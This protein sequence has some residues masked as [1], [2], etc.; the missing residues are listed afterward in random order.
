MIVL[1]PARLDVEKQELSIGVRT[2]VLQRKPY[3]VFLYLIENRHRMVGR[4]ELL[5]RFWDGQ[6][7]YDQSLSK[8]VG[9]IRKALGDSGP[10]LIETRWGL[11]Y[12]YI[13]PFSESPATVHASIPVIE[14]P[15]PSKEDA[16]DSALPAPP[17]EAQAANPTIELGAANPIAAAAT[18]PISWPAT[19]RRAPRSF[20]SWLLPS[21]LVVS[22]LAILALA[23][24][25]F[26]RHEATPAPPA[27]VVPLQ[28]RSIAVLPFTGG[29]K[30]SDDQYMGLELADAV[31]VR[32]MTVSQLDVRSSTTVR[33]VLGLHG[34][35]SLAGA[36]LAVQDVVVGEM[37]RAKDTV[38]LNV[39]LLDSATGTILWSGT[40]NADNTNIFT[41]E[42][43]IARQVA[44]AL[45]PQLGTNA[46][47]RSPAQ[48][49]SRPEAYS[50][51]MKAKFFATT[52]TRDSLAKAIALL[53]EAIRIDPNY[54][55]A[56]ATLADC[57]QL[58][59]FYGFAPPSDAYPRAE[60]AA[61]KALSLDNSIGEAHVAWMSALAD[62]DWD[63]RGAEREFKAT[64]AIDPNYAVAYQ[65]YGYAL[66]AMN[67]GDE[68][69][70]AM[71]QAALLDPV[72][73]SIQTT[74]AWGYYL[75]REYSQAVD[76]C[77]RVLELYPEFVPAHQLLGIVYSQMGLNQ[78]SMTELT[79]A[80][81]LER[82]D[83]I[84]PVLLDYE[85]AREGK[86]NEATRNLT[87]IQPKPQ[88]SVV[89]DYYVAAAWAATG[90]TQKAQSY[91]D[92]AFLAHSNWVIYLHYDPRFDGL[93][94]E[95]AFQA[96]LHRVDTLHSAPI[97]TVSAS[98]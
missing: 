31:A 40:F 24:F 37:H 19:D 77:K 88:G 94:H 53:S 15:D 30:D 3:L 20:P 55:P 32:L 87:S 64:I 29:L 46:I 22:I 58:Q 89:P 96:L 83:E 66:F 14:F 44:G 69:L 56:Y 63:W 67:R 60:A 68:G 86:R 71:K 6:E 81:T 43:S 28:V 7:V 25:A 38:V 12:R 47:K 27:T 57:F 52:R 61:Q 9:T 93:R 79:K 42:D 98:R 49:T 74:L 1:G 33:S 4:K 62:Y 5:D 48:E 51:Y 91:L 34:D 84:T 21:L 41:T 11:G 18:E 92:R 70:V 80:E 76:Q 85:L 73:P 23:T 35:A 16:L 17:A 10:E 2:V 8:A 36:K 78:L 97:P 72:S 90:D 95:Q 59:G 26:R 45:M 54:A 82:D 50:A 13:G 75:S 65:Y 39:R